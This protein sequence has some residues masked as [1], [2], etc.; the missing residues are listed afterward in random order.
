LLT[1]KSPINCENTPLKGDKGSFRFKRE[2]HLKRRKEIQ[3][4]FNKGKRFGVRGVRLLVLKNDLPRNRICFSFPR[5]FGNA[6]KR[7]RSKR[8]S[9][10]AFRLLKPRLDTGYDLILLVYPE[11]KAQAL[12]TAD[13]SALSKKATLHSRGLQLEI[14]F[15]K[16][17][18]LE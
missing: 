8:L 11:E 4:V 14:L 18:L 16:A 17:G 1:R 2:E 6:V 13:V 15:T 9:R 3:G 5:G 12:Q 10:E 7:N